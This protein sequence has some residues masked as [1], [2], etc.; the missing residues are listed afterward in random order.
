MW[1]AAFRSKHACA[2]MQHIEG[3]PDRVVAGAV[4]RRL[5]DLLSDSSL[6]REVCL[7]IASMTVSVSLWAA[8][9]NNYNPLL[10]A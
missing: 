5:H 6:W 8:Y 3:L 1:Y 2:Q 9:V 4:C 10:I 7:S